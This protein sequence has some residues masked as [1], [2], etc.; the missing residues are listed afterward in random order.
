MENQTDILTGL[1]S[2]KKAGLIKNGVQATSLLLQSWCD[3]DFKK[4]PPEFSRQMIAYW[5]PEA[6]KARCQALAIDRDHITTVECVDQTPSHVSNGY[7]Y[8]FCR[9]VCPVSETVYGARII[10]RQDGVI[11]AFYI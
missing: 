4:L 1:D 6:Q 3:G 8:L 10:L 2:G 11:M 7:I 5:T 9:Y